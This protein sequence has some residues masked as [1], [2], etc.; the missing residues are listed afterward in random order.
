MCL[1]GLLAEGVISR[2]CLASVAILPRGLLHC[3]YCLADP[4]AALFGH[5]QKRGSR[6]A[7][8]M[9]LYSSS[10][11]AQVVRGRGLVELEPPFTSCAR[12]VSPAG[13]LK[14]GDLKKAIRS[15]AVET[16]GICRAREEGQSMDRWASQ[17]VERCFFLWC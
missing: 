12:S 17:D 14:H 3:A 5:V 4:K 8:G 15:V 9:G 7:L 16:D 2:S 1:F 11:L 10:M 6:V 13:I